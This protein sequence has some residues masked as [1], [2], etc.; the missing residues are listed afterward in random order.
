[1]NGLTLATVTLACDVAAHNTTSIFTTLAT[2][3]RGTTI[4]HYLIHMG[5]ASLCSQLDTHP[6]SSHSALATHSPSQPPTSY[7][8]PVGEVGARW[9]YLTSFDCNV[10]WAMDIGEAPDKELIIDAMSKILLV[11]VTST[12]TVAQKNG[13]QVAVKETT[14]VSGSGSGVFGRS[15]METKR[16]MRTTERMAGE[17]DAEGGMSQEAQE[18]A[19]PETEVET[20][21]KMYSSLTPWLLHA[22]VQS[23][24]ENS[25]LK[26]EK[27][28]RKVGKHPGEIIGLL[29]ERGV[30]YVDGV[31]VLHMKSNITIVPL[32]DMS[33]QSPAKILWIILG[34]ICLFIIMVMMIQKVNEECSEQMILPIL[35]ELFQCCRSMQMRLFSRF[36]EQKTREGKGGEEIEEEDNEDN[37]GS[38]SGGVRGSFSG[39]DALLERKP[40]LSHSSNRGG[41][42]ASPVIPR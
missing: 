15:L 34:T 2:L 30:N 26:I 11:I 32:Q 41:H 3:H 27:A 37:E 18:E 17:E 24:D 19:T 12:M 13:V 14:A 21:S 36:F 16:T 35:N 31:E 40:F 9:W 22:T 25:L 10:T 5:H 4:P 1:M 28:L 8:T 29:I 23:E 39:E 6:H 33:R 20:E 7:P 38:V 42:H